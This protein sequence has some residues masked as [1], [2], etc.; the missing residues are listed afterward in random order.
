[1]KRVYYCHECARNECD[2]SDCQ[3]YNLLPNYSSEARS[4]EAITPEHAM[5]KLSKIRLARIAAGITDEQLIA[6][7][8]EIIEEKRGRHQ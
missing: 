6:L 2:K 5:L 7:V 4:V 8:Q 3:N 1:M